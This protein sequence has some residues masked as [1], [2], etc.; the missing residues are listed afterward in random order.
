VARAYTVSFAL[1]QLAGQGGGQ[2]AAVVGRELRRRARRWVCAVEA[3]DGAVPAV[4]D[5]AAV[6]A[7]DAAQVA[8]AGGQAHRAFGTSLALFQDEVHGRARLADR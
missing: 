4:G 3:A 1:V 5:L 7:V 6:E 8:G 2:L